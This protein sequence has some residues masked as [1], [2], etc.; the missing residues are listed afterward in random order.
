[1]TLSE[2]DRKIL[3]LIQRDARKPV[4]EIAEAAGLSSSAAWRRIKAMEDAGII[5]AYPALVDADKVGLTFSA[6]VH[7]TLSKHEAAPVSAFIARIRDRPEVVE[8][9]ATTGEADYHLRVICRDKDA[10]NEFLEE[11]LFKLP[12]LAHIRTNLVLKNI[13]RQTYLS[14]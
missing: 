2:P 9:Y 1:M 12:A 5:T 8:C 3:R 7:V 14:V 10:Y 11:F 6:I 4:S 13:K